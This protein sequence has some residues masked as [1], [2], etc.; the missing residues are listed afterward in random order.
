MSKKA[1]KKMQKAS[2]KAEKKQAY[3]QENVSSV[4]FTE[5]SRSTLEAVGLH[6]LSGSAKILSV[7]IISLNNI[8]LY[9]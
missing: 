2:E 5:L 1:L 7:R 4:M 3:K 9:M 6:H 8:Q